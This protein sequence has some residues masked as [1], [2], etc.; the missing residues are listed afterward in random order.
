MSSTVTVELA[1]G[2]SVWAGGDDDFR[3]SRGGPV[4]VDV[5]G[6]ENLLAAITAAEAAGVLIVHDGERLDNV[7]ETQEESE[8][9]YQDARDATASLFAER[10]RR[11]MGTQRLPEV[12]ELSREDVE[13]LAL[14]GSGLHRSLLTQAP[15][16]Q[17]TFNVPARSR[18]DFQALADEGSEYHEIVLEYEDKMAAA[19]QEEL[20]RES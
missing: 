2:F 7:V 12:V 15:K 17:E 20:E 16:D 13:E 5:A 19:A 4:E 10:D 9:R 3:I 11:L 1:P 8:R 6:N 18:E 14:D